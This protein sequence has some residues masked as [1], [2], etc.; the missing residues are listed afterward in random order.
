[1]A[2]ELRDAD[3]ERDPRARGRLLEDHPDRAAGKD[4]LFFAGCVL[5]AG[6]GVQHQ[7]E[8]SREKS[9]TRVKWRPLSVSGMS[10]TGR[11]VRRPLGVGGEELAEATQAGEHAAL[12]RSEGDAEALGELRLGQAAVVGELECLSL[13]AWS[14][15]APPAPRRAGP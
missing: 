15:S 9:A 11:I 4:A 6:R 1:M 8:P 2:A 7:L 14:R 3:L 13:V 5:D 12:D 10:S